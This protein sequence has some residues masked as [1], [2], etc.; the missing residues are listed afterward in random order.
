LTCRNKRYTW[1]C[2]L[3]FMALSLLMWSWATTNSA[4]QNAVP[5]VVVRPSVGWASVTWTGN[6][7]PYHL[8]RAEIDG[9]FARKQIT[10]RELNR[11]QAEYLKS[12]QPTLSFFKW[13]YASYT[14]S[15]QQPPITQPLGLGTG[16][17]DQLPDPHCY[18]YTRLRFLYAASGEDAQLAPLARRLIKRDPN[19]FEVI[20]SFVNFYYPTKPVIT[21]QEALADTQRLSKLYPSRNQVNAQIG[22][23]YY[24][25]WLENRKA[26]DGAKAVYYYQKF[27]R[28]APKSDPFRSQAELLIGDIQHPTF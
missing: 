17:F 25:D 27:L 3:T 16:I 21:K 18:D 13:G 10:P 15:K 7:S 20:Y 9:A 5:P 26:S 19:D 14:G 2:L 12:K 28:L 1:S 22:G 23:I 6:N 24:K 8:V 4:G 11:Y